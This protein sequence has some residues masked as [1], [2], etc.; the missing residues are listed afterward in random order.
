MKSP[1]QY[2]TDELMPFVREWFR[3]NRASRK[4]QPRAKV[5]RPCQHCSR[6]FGARDLRAHVPVCPKKPKKLRLRGATTTKGAE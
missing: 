4:H 5:K 3:R 6:M 2:S 1:E